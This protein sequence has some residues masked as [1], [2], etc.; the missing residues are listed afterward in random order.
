MTKKRLLALLCAAAMT[1][2]MTACTGNTGD[3]GN[4]GDTGASSGT[5]GDIVIGMTVNNTGADPYQTA[6]Y[7]AAEAHAKE[8]GVTLK[9]L[10]PVGDVTKQQNQVQDL[11]GMNCDTIV[12]WPCNSEAGVSLVKQINKAGIPV[13]T[14]NTNVAE[15]GNEYTSA[16][17][18]LQTWKR[19]SR[20]RS[21]W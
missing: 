13:M 9:I 16:T 8:L 20:P 4:T 11:I 19:A 21:R 2:S 17:S 7:A 14:A 18:A 10:D 5:D 12:L 3:S 15:A 6:Y 1:V